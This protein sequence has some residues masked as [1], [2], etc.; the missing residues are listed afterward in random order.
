MLLTF[1]VN[2]EAAT[3]FTFAGVLGLESNLDAAVATRGDV[4]S[5]GFLVAMLANPYRRSVQGMAA[6]T[7]PTIVP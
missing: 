7:G 2:A 6:W 5:V 3:V 1:C 4:V